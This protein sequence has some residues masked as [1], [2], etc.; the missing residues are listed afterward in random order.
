MARFVPQPDRQPGQFVPVAQCA[1]AGDIQQEVLAGRRSETEPTG[2]EHPQEMP[3]QKNQHV[4]FDGAQPADDA[5][6]PRTDLV[7]RLSPGQP[8]RNSSQSAR[9]ASI[10]AVPR[11]PLNSDDG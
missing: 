9:S 7:R 1:Q 5:V 3:V 8:S 6:G 11:E 2:S 4:A 10:S